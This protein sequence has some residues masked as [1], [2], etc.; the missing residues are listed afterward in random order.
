MLVTQKAKLT[1]ASPRGPVTKAQGEAPA[2]VLARSAAQLGTVA[3]HALLEAVE[4][5]AAAVLKATLAA[6]ARMP[7]TAQMGT[8]GAPPAIKPAPRAR[9]KAADLD[10]AQV[11]FLYACISFT[12]CGACVHFCCTIDARVLL[13]IFASWY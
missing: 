11:R 13:L 1:P 9:Q 6:P 2:P 12:D 8:A 3:A 5:N 10:T 7:K 4:T